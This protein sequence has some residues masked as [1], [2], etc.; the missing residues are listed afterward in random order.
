MKRFLNTI[1]LL[2]AASAIFAK[3]NSFSRAKSLGKSTKYNVVSRSPRKLIFS[4]YL[5]VN[6]DYSANNV[7]DEGKVNHGEKH[8][9]FGPFQDAPVPAFGLGG[10]MPTSLGLT[11]QPY[12]YMYGSAMMHP[13]NPMNGMG[14][15]GGMGGMPGLG[16]MGGQGMGPGPQVQS[17]PQNNLSNINGAGYNDVNEFD[18]SADD[19]KLNQE[20]DMTR[21]LKLFDDPLNPADG[22]YSECKDAQRQ[23]IDI[24]NAIMKKQNKVIYQEIMKYLL[25]SKYLIAMTEIKMT[26][27]LRTKIYDLMSTYSSVTEDQIESIPLNKQNTN[28]QKT[29]NNN[30]NDYVT[31]PQEFGIEEL[32]FDDN[33]PDFGT[34]ERRRN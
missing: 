23:A 27:A 26:R 19:V 15:M 5:N 2:L 34:L 17:A 33:V 30:I 14:A 1:I 13:M 18:I 7:G 11:N 8:P 24:S 25:K 22:V 6:Q 16:G 10:M 12:N 4:P 9:E 28:S 3:S 20:Y 31:T 32:N 21:K 29:K